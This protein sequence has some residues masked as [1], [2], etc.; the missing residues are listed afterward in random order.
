MGLYL[1]IVSVLP[2]LPADWLDLSGPTL[3]GPSWLHS[4]APNG[5]LSPPCP[6]YL[7]DCALLI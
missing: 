1:P 5:G 3:S 2:L 4:L 7:D 6:I